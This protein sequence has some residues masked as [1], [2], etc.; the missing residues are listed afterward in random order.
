MV[1]NENFV[2][3]ADSLIKRLYINLTNKCN[4]E[5]PFCCAFSKPSNNIFL[6]FDQF[7]SIINYHNNLNEPYEVELEGGEP[8]LHPQFTN[9]VE[10]LAQQKLLKTL[11][12]ISNGVLVDKYI[13]FLYAVSQKKKVIMKF[14]VNYYLLEQDSNLLLQL[15]QRIEKYPITDNWVMCLSIRY[16]TPK[17]L[18]EP[19]LLQLNAGKLAQYPRNCYAIEYVGRAKKN[20]YGGSAV[21][22][23]MMTASCIPTI[24]SCSGICFEHNFEARRQYEHTILESNK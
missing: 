5:C 1:N 12:I 8:L 23:E 15:E 4:R 2:E 17:K 10:F 19:W 3:E 14:S 24:Y 16:R 22:G 13:D 18:D 9:I 11:I 21:T 6:S 20:K 7:Q